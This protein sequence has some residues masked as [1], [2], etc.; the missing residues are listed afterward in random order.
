MTNELFACVDARDTP[1]VLEHLLNK[2][3]LDVNDCWKVALI[4]FAICC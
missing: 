1:E 2:S 3:Q 4:D